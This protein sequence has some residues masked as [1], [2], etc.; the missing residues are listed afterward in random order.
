MKLVNVL[1]VLAVLVVTASYGVEEYFHVL[2]FL[3][4]GVGARDDRS[5]GSGS[6]QPSAARPQRASGPAAQHAL[7]VGLEK[8]ARDGPQ[9]STSPDLAAAPP[10]GDYPLHIDRYPLDGCIFF[11]RLSGLMSVHTALIWARHSGLDPVF[12]TSRH[13]SGL[14]RLAGQI[15]YCS[16]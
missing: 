2:S 5:V 10:S 7:P 9:G 3:K 11:R 14:S 12:P 16:S 15:E 6:D 13:P 1:V 4:I 8:H